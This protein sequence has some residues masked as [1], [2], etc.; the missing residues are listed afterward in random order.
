MELKVDIEF[1]ELLKLVKQLPASKLIQL[2]SAI[3]N[4][5]IE[6]K[7]KEEI[8]DFQRF[9]LEAPVMS[10]DQYEQFLENRKHF[11]EWRKN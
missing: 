8:S 10:D 4:D 1:D 11:N 9:L 3:E 2:K 7:S 6:T 5:I